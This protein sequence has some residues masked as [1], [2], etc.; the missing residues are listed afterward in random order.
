MNGKSSEL[1]SPGVEYCLLPLTCDSAS[2]RA[3]ALL[4]TGLDFGD[5]EPGSAYFV[6]MA[7]TRLRGAFRGEVLEDTFN[8]TTA[9]RGAD[10]ASE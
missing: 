7:E 8:S 6:S 10:H 5:I 2:A 4:S 1:S 3:V 9:A